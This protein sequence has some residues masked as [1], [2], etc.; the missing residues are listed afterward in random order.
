MM[1]M[2]LVTL[3]TSRVVLEVLGA[4]DFGIYN[5][6]GGVVV[7]FGFLNSAMSSA[8][9]RFLSFEL[10]RKDFVQLKKVFSVSVTIHV[11]IALLIFIFAETVGLWFL[12]TQLTI[13]DERMNA[14]NWVYQFSI[15]AFMVNV[16]SVPYNAAIISHERMN[17]YAYISIVEVILKLVIVFALQWFGLDKLK[18][19]AILVFTVSIIIR[20]MYQ[21]YCK[22]KFEECLYRFEW[23]RTLFI[24]MFG[25]AGWNVIGNFAY[26]FRNQGSNILLNMFFGPTVNAARA[27]AYQLDAAVE[28]FVNNFQTA[29]NPQIIKSYASKDY[30]YSM[31]L[32]YSGSKYT[33]FLMLLLS[34]PIILQAEFILS[35]WLKEVPQYT[36]LFVQIVLING[37]ID[38][39]SKSLKTI[40]KASGKV[41][42]YMAIQGGFYLFA[43]PVIYLFLKWGYSPISSMIVLAVFTFFGTFLRLWLVKRVVPEF[44]VQKFAI[45]VFLNALLVGVLSVSISYYLN[46]YVNSDELWNMIIHTISYLLITASIIWFVGIGHSERRVIIGYLK[47]TSRGKRFNG[48]MDN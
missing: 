12:N 1:L 46:R 36:V 22:R 17:V 32:I 23:D 42:V 16:I 8:T 35:L 3:Y 25:F 20:A 6:V 47:K 43:L 39:V 33:Y 11:L 4:E 45:K 34:L 37:L 24:T 7:L 48:R 2:M 18:L 29:M 26:V 28:Q 9:Q 27:V 30:D 31:K 13:P 44:S 21:I 10:G 15:L 41:S 38:S 40:V 19:Y 14:A 5:V